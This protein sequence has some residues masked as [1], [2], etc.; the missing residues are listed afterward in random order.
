MSDNFN[1]VNSVDEDTFEIKIS[2]QNTVHSELS[3]KSLSD[4]I[5]AYVEE[6]NP[7]IALLTPC[8]GG[9]CHLN[10]VP[11]LM[12][13]TQVLNSFGIRT[14]HHFCRNDSLITRARNNLI[15]KA[16]SDPK[17]THFMFIDSDIS[18]DA[19]D[20]MKLLLSNQMLIGG[21]YPLKKYYWS[22]ILKDQQNPY[23][24]NVIQEMMTSKRNALSLNSS[25]I[26]DEDLL[27]CN[28]VKYNVNFLDARLKIEKN[29]AKVMHV[30]TGFMMIQRELLTKM[31]THFASTKYVDDI[32]FLSGEENDFAYALFDCSVQDGHYL[33][34]D[35]MFCDR[36]RNM[37]GDVYIDISINLTHTGLE[38]F[39]G[40]F[41][42]SIA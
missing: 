14:V 4:Q 15:A 26:I 41:L 20:V 21:V 38:D 17:T 13:T 3:P 39:K 2:P 25:E 7:Q 34:E 24:T 22:K 32:G 31:Q 10:Y 6:N 29:L 8:Y 19:T 12:A 27:R 37:G 1:V 16:M 40:S 18:W 28:I 33:S 36:W 30:A 9:V 23:N 11:C 42:T 5:I 35:W